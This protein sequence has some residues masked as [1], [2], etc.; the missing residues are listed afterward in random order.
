MASS[1]QALLICPREMI[2]DSDGE[3]TMLLS[4]CEEEWDEVFEAANTPPKA[5]NAGMVFKG[6]G[7]SRLAG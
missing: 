4:A 3:I 5:E 6:V 2:D 1:P 7:E